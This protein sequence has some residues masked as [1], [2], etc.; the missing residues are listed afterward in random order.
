MP[1][2]LLLLMLLLQII[3]PGDGADAA[4]QDILVLAPLSQ[5]LR[6]GFL[7]MVFSNW[8]FSIS[9]TMLK[10]IGIS[11]FGMPRLHSRQSFGWPTWSSRCTT[12]PAFLIS[13]RTGVSSCLMELPPSGHPTETG[14]RIIPL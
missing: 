14:R 12:L 13:Q 2:Q 7:R 3:K 1:E 8:D 9:T 4:S 10:I 5:V 11:V 6:P